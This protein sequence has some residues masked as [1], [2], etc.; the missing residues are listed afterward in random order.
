MEF[1]TPRRQRC[2]EFF[3]AQTD[4]LIVIVRADR[5]N[6]GVLVIWL[7]WMTSSNFAR[8]VPMFFR[9]WSCPMEQL[10]TTTFLKRKSLR[11]AANRLLGMGDAEPFP[12]LQSNGRPALGSVWRAG[13]GNRV[14][15]NG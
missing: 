5:L 9:G 3:L 14:S 11:V 7:H 13:Q 15:V 6:L 4:S 12:Y 10:L 1:Q 8:F 2:V